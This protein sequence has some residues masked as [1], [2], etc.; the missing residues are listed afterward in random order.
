[1]TRALQGALLSFPLPPGSLPVSAFP[2]PSPALAGS[3]VGMS[4]GP[5]RVSALLFPPRFSPVSFPL[6]CVQFFSTFVPRGSASGSFRLPFVRF[7]PPSPMHSRSG[8]LARLRFPR[9]RVAVVFSPA[10][11]SASFPFLEVS[12]LS[13]RPVHFPFVQFSPLRFDRISLVLQTSSM[14]P[15]F[16]SIAGSTTPSSGF[17]SVARGS[18]RSAPHTTLPERQLRSVRQWC[19]NLSPNEALWTGNRGLWVLIS[20]ALRDVGSP[21]S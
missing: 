4:A 6:P 12:S 16:L 19:I 20:S 10:F 7:S 21:V 3:F 1:M 15:G 2:L 9:L 18:R 17:G 5:P 14:I 13:L 11:P 8:W